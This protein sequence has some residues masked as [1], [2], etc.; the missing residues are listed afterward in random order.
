MVVVSGQVKREMIA[1]SYPGLGMRQ[2]GD[3]EVDIVSIV[4]RDH[5][6][7]GSRR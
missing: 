2:L 7:R 5:Q 3:Q 4:R 6:V 1:G